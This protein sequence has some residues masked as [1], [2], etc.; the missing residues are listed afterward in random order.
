V[1]WLG[2]LTGAVSEAL[3]RPPALPVE[4]H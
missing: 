1:A 3:V 4:G 2:S